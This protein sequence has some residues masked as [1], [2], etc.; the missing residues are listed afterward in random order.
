ML[1]AARALLFALAIIAPPQK[2]PASRKYTAQE[3]ARE[4]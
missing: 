1:A 2:P 4:H 3:I